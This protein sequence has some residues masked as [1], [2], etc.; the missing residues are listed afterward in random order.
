MRHTAVFW[1]QY[2]R[3]EEIPSLIISPWSILPEPVEAIFPRLLNETHIDVAMGV[4]DMREVREGSYVFHVKSSWE[5]DEGGRRSCVG[6]VGFREVRGESWSIE[7]GEI[8]FG[9]VSTIGGV[10]AKQLSTETYHGERDSG[11]LSRRT[12]R[13]A[14]VKQEFDCRFADLMQWST[15]ANWLLP[16]QLCSQSNALLNDVFLLLFRHLVR[17][18]EVYQNMAIGQIYAAHL[19]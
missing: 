4:W 14:V 11:R 18:L 5:L 19:M 16:C 9:V 12:I 17:A 6:W 1:V 3:E 8:W 7:R 13:E 2:Q 15:I 10:Y